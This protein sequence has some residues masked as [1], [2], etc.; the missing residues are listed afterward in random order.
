MRI[1]TS[2]CLITSLLFSSLVLFPSTIQAKPSKGLAKARSSGSSTSDNASASEILTVRVTAGNGGNLVQ[3]SIQPDGQ[4][5]G[6]YIYRIQNGRMSLGTRMSGAASATGALSYQWFD[7]NGTQDSIYY[8]ESINSKNGAARQYHA[9]VSARGRGQSAG[10]SSSAPARDDRRVQVFPASPDSS[11]TSGAESNITNQWLVAGQ[12]ALKIQIKSDSW[13]RVTQQQMAGAGFNPQVDIRNL[14]LFGDGVEIA[15]LTNKDTGQLISGDYLE[16]YG[17]G[18]DTDEADSRIYYLIAGSAQGK[19]IQG[20]LQTE[21][22]PTPGPVPSP[23]P[24][25]PG[26]L[27]FSYRGWFPQLLDLIRPED[28]ASARAEE[29]KRPVNTVNP[30]QPKPG[31]APASP[32]AS[33]APAATASPNTVASPT[34]EVVSVKPDAVIAEPPKSVSNAPAPVNS[35][36]IVKKKKRKANHQA[37][38]SRQSQKSRKRSKIR[39]NHALA[40]MAG[41]ILS[42]RDTL[43]I[44]ERFNYNPQLPN[45]FNFFGSTI[46]TTFPLNKTIAIHNLQAAAD[47]PALLTI[48]LQGISL[49][50]HQANVL[51]NGTPIGTINNFFGHDRLVQ[52]FS[53]PLSQLIEG[54]NTVRIEPVGQVQFLGLD[55]LSLTYPHSY[56]AF[57]NSLRFT[58]RAT[59]TLQVDGFTSSAIRL[60]DISDPTTVK[61][62]RPFV[63][64]VTGGYAI[65]VPG[66]QP[67]KAARTMIALPEGQFSTPAGFSLN[68]PSSLN[69]NAGAQLL[70]IANK[71]FI[72][73]LGPLVTKRQ[74]QGYSVLVADV[75]DVYDE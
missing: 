2:V 66:S 27:D 12:S 41:P 28:G 46:G 47:G 21:V 23:P 42:F 29:G 69:S 73:S 67:T 34:G 14:S 36:A 54:N 31:V 65:T 63:A 45:G 56:R 13:Y 61:V 58:S 33:D 25:K 10:E 30:V 18:L 17:R 4:N 74:Q 40:Y 11:G 59:Q 37:R 49:Q 24:A 44:K 38:Q 35:K 6:F 9:V 43:Q 32:T 19:R 71:D 8:I 3:W 50:S 72:P 1:Q 26:G 39:H 75:E 16:F 64:A 62:T 48:G 22:V 5:P 7:P 68:Q 52:S 55:Y 20:N 60:I 51:L 70:I 53:I 57:D 15:I